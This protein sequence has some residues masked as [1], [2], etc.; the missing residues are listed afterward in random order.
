MTLV[1]DA[2]VVTEL[3]L[4]TSR[5]LA[6][7]TV[8]GDE[9]LVAPPHLTADVVSVLRGWSL[10][11]HLADGQARRALGELRDLDIVFVPV[12]D[13]V[14]VWALRQY[15]S[16]YDAMYVVLA[17]ALDADLLTLDRRLGAAAPDC[18][19]VL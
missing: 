10:G 18:A 4:G 1:V 3:L 13:L 19:R 6:A 16:A 11:G 5:G 14:G 15:I 12:D 7:S 9:P 2:S 17:R 8:I